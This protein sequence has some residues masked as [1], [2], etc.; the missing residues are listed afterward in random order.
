MRAGLNWTKFSIPMVFIFI[1]PATSIALFRYPVCIYIFT[2]CLF[3]LNTAG[4]RAQSC[5]ASG[6]TTVSTFVNTYYP[7]ITATLPAGSSSISLG[8]VTYGATPINSGDVLLIIQMQGAQISAANDSTYGK[9]ISG[10]GRVNGYLNNTQLLAGN[11]EYVV[12]TNP[13]G[14]T[15]GTVNLASPTIN[16]YKNADFGTDGQYRYQVIP[17]ASY[18]NLIIGANIFAPAWNGTSGGVI[19]IYAS[20]NIDLNGKVI[21][22]AAAGFRGGG[23]ISM[24]G[25]AGLLN[26]GFVT[27]SSSTANGSKGEGIAGMPRFVNNNNTLLDN[28]AALEGYPGGSFAAGA[29]GNAGGGG[30]DGNPINN[31][32][33]SG[34]GGGSN[35]GPGGKG[36]NSW[37]SNMVVGGEPG[38]TFAQATT[39][40][41]VMGGGGGAGTTNNATGT[42][43]GGFASSGAAGGGIVL[44]YAGSFTNTGTIDVSGGSANNTVL[45]DGA[46]G[47]GAGGSVVIKGGSGVAGITV[48]AN[49]GN[50]GNNDGGG[51][52]PHG[53]GGG[54]GGGLIYAN[55][56]LN[57]ASSA[58]GGMHG[59]TNGG[60][61][62]NALSGGS[63]ISIQ[64]PAITAP[65]LCQVLPVN[66][67]YLSAIRNNNIQLTWQVN[68]EAGIRGYTI[69]RS[70]NGIDFI[71]AGTADVRLSGAGQYSFVDLLAITA[72]DVYYRVKAVKA[73]GDALYSTI[74]TV[75][76]TACSSEFFVAPNPV[77]DLASLMVTAAG[78]GMAT[79][80]LM[81]ISG[82]LI[83]QVRHPV[84]RG[85]NVL[86][87]QPLQALHNGVYLLQYNDGHI[88]R[89]KVLVIEH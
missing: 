21:S 60:I 84:T 20:G 10:D 49:G 43:A 47:G 51:S 64:T 18:N 25:A 41:L 36:G 70:F 77:K 4:L 54:G 32:E 12:A 40:R 22:A 83:W 65:L 39:N 5:P 82:R 26:T 55:M 23:G 38:A 24:T 48:Y 53:P 52:G 37:S 17:V 2:I 11:M 75:K 35:G 34:G 56:P 74:A 87:L 89:E 46:G 7:G 66:F 33:N 1:G 57:A 9:G 63:G 72:G 3:C 71:P 6:T 13:V 44:L 73:N 16:S 29:P 28:G 88:S 42:P 85:F 27:A 69:E 19:V 80:R 67:L 61:S 59:V 58:N 50:G 79:L 62:Y 8:A 81:D 76:G 30:T 14:L 45:N 86:R 78:G 31:N 15:G 68:N